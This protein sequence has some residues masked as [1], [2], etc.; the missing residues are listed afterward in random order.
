MKKLP[1][2]S[3]SFAVKSLKK[4]MDRKQQQNAGN[5]EKTDDKRVHKR[6]RERKPDLAAEEIND[7][8]QRKSKCS[9]QQQLED[10]AEGFGKNAEQQDHAEYDR[11]DRNDK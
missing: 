5:A 6:Q 8:Q 7:P 9:I 3:G 4:E 2:L 1:G 11:G 10:E